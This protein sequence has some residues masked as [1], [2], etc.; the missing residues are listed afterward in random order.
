[1]LVYAPTGAGKT[2]IAAS[3]MQAERGRV[4]FVAPWRELIGQ[5][6]AKLAE[7]GVEAGVVMGS[8]KN[9]D[10]RVLV[11]SIETVRRVE[12]LPDCELVV[13]DEAHRA[14]TDLRRALLTKW[15]KARHLLLSATPWREGYGGLNDIADTMTS[16]ANYSELIKAGYLVQPTLYT[17]AEPTEGKAVV[18]AAV[19]EWTRL[20][21]SLRT[22][23]FTSTVAESKG[24]T[25]LLVKRG[26][27]AAHIDGS[28][29]SIER[30]RI[31]NA[32]RSGELQVITNCNC[33]CEGFDCP[34]LQCVV[35][36][37]CDSLSWYVQAVGR[38]MRPS[39]GKSSAI[40]IDPAGV[41][42]RFGPAW[43]DREWSLDR[44][45]E[46]EKPLDDTVKVIP[47][48]A[49]TE[50]APPLPNLALVKWDG[51]EGEK[52]M[53]RVASATGYGPVWLA[54]ELTRING[55][56]PPSLR[57]RVERALEG[58]PLRAGKLKAW[59]Q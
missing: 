51:E 15:P 56:A 8:R 3:L 48:A 55:F 57:P 46:T 33:L 43:A 16:A 26:I 18:E 19:R 41:A 9:L 59:F 44:A 17:L 7:M 2:V 34:P 14:D 12:N 30:N 53:R 6:V 35:L 38:V 58:D 31:V 45:P 39:E 52:V 36:R 20:A 1:V 29:G 5:T 10:A 40:V 11:C 23:W 37:P 42:H 28:M 54:R 13:V 32:L 49:L 22:L 21:A 24:L 27:K 4:V 50:T 47:S 25:E